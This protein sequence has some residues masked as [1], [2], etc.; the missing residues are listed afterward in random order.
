VDEDGMSITMDPDRNVA[1][2][3]LGELWYLG[4][5]E[6]RIAE[7]QYIAYDVSGTGMASTIRAYDDLDGTDTDNDTLTTSLAVTSWVPSDP[8]KY[9]V[10]RDSPTGGAANK[11]ARLLEIHAASLYG[12]H[13]L[14][15]HSI[16][17]L[18]D[19]LKFSDIIGYL[20]E[21]FQPL[22]PITQ[23]DESSFV[24]PHAVWLDPV[25]LGT[26]LSEGMTTEINRNWAV[27]EGFEYRRRED[28]GHTWDLKRS[29]GARFINSGEAA[30]PDV[31][32]VIVVYTA[33]DGSVKWA[34]PPGSGADVTDSALRDSDP[35]NPVNASNV[36][37]DRYLV[38]EADGLDSTKAIEA[39]TEA[40]EVA[41]R[42]RFVG[43]VQVPRFAWRDGVLEP[44][45]LMR[46]DDW[47]KD[48]EAGGERMPLSAVNYSRSGERPATATVDLPANRL[49]AE[50]ARQGLRP[51]R[52]R[53][54]QIRK[55]YRR[56]RKARHP[57]GWGSTGMGR[58]GGGQGTGVG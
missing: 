39:G 57:K 43:E 6:K 11:P 1:T 58:G 34:G 26:I 4:N 22:L 31:N 46:A 51:Q 30:E 20:I 45:S 56:L 21:R 2:T 7:V 47:V 3:A 37:G 42:P 50:L 12:I 55:R 13:D 54:A 35:S 48:S 23:I 18:P 17:G 52:V 19:G 9:I 10:I 32:A 44:T 36:V 14:P 53:R 28:V 49:D 16:D 25:S 27:W 5:D 24:M 38:V 41:L 15:R 33:K 40:L 8:S 29:E